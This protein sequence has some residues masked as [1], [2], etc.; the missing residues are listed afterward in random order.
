M[1][2]MT[3]P[4]KHHLNDALLMAYSAGAL[5]EASD[6]VV[7][8]HI[9]LCDECRIRMMAY[10][11]VGGALIDAGAPVA[12]DGGSLAATMTRIANDDSAPGRAPDRGPSA[13]S[14]PA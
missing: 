9:S 8:T 4:I 10:D 14:W 7:A 11:A 6:L 1:N 12:M 2:K 13:R 5:P 3:L